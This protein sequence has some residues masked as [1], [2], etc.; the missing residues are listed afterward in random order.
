MTKLAS[1]I[2]SAAVWTL[3]YKE[4]ISYSVSGGLE[5][6][7]LVCMAHQSRI[8]HQW[9]TQKGMSATIISISSGILSS[10][11]PILFAIAVVTHTGV[12]S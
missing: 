5:T 10:S 6:K 7:A 4:G 2:T 9:T 11:R 8:F 1:P 12:R 3:Q